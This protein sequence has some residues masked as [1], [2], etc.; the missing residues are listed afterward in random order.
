[1]GSCGRSTRG[2][3][4]VTSNICSTMPRR[5]AGGKPVRPNEGSGR[6][7]FPMTRVSDAGHSAEPRDSPYAT[8]ASVSNY[9]RARGRS[10]TPAAGGGSTGR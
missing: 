2:R 1:M 5:R 6:I 7:G 4:P 8:A 3:S 10:D 9:D